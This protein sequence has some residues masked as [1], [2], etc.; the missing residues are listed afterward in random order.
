VIQERITDGKTGFDVCN[1]GNASADPAAFAVNWALFENP[2][3]RPSRP[4]DGPAPGGLVDTVKWWP[5]R[6]PVSFS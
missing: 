2:I 5:T 3:P 4:W 6:R 1:V